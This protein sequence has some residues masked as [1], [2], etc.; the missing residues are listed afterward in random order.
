MAE[1]DQP[2]N[3]GPGGTSAGSEASSDRKR[4]ADPGWRRPVR[5]QRH[6]I[7]GISTVSA[8]WGGTTDH[9]PKRRLRAR[10]EDRLQR[11]RR[12]YGRFS[13]AQIQITSKSGTN[14]FHG[15]AFFKASRPGLNAYQRW[16]G[17]GTSLC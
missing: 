7:D 10:H 12:E 1:L 13:G 11:L 4:T 15:S 14:Q 16:N 2:G 8:V 6:H 5:N 9:H 17:P 3:Q